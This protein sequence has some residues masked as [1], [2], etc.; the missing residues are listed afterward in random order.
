MRTR[1]DHWVGC[2]AMAGL[3]AIMIC[4]LAQGQVLPRN[5]APAKAA[6]QPAVPAPGETAGQTRR[7]G[8]QDARDARETARETGANPRAAARETRHDTRQ[9]IQATRAADLG[10]WFNGRATSGLVIADTAANSVFAN[11]GFR[12]G[13]RIVSIN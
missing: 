11:A 13:D 3:T 12:A 2:L 8:R 1:F 9:N 7:D 6:A 10:L 5:K 4:P